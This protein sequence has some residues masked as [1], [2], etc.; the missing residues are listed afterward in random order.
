MMKILTIALKDITQSFR[1]FLAIAMMFLVP[2]LITGLFALLFGGGGEEESPSIDLPIIPVQIVNLDQGVFGE[3]IV[4]VLSSTE[5]ADLLAVTETQSTDTARAAVDN[6]QANAAVIIP[7]DLSE[8]LSIPGEQTEIEIYQ[9]PTLKLGPGIIS[10]I[11]NQLTD[12]FSGSNIA[13]GVINQ[14]LAESGISLSNE[15]IQSIVSRYQSA[16]EEYIGNQVILSIET[17]SGEAGGNHGVAGILSMVMGGMMI[18]YTFFT[19][20]NSAN[21]LLTE[22]EN[23]TLGRMLT[24]ATSPVEVIAGKLVA[25][26]MMVFVQIIVLLGFGWLVFDI[27]WGELWMLALYTIAVTLGAVT[28]GLFAIS[29]AKDRKQASLI[30]GAGVTVTGMLGMSS[31]F[32][33][34]SPNP[35]QAIDSLSLMVPQGWANRALIHIMDG[36]SVPD[37]LISLLGLLIYSAVMFLI[38]YKRFIKRF[39]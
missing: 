11:V 12:G 13:V 18:F 29:W 30:V 25:G 27:Y 31:I 15:Q 39:A 24:T 22:E 16:Y 20:T 8:S 37:V 10:S 6:Q 19:G 36:F 5:L 7:V 23:L 26:A 35:N 21:S 1:S 2:I 33:L 9:D 17:P 28:F 32:M 14:Q 34:N 4:N 3:T 38:G